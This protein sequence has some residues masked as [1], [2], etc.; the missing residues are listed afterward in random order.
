MNDDATLLRD[1]CWKLYAEHCTHMR[2]HETQRST[3]AASILAIAT[4][5]V[6][7]ITFDKKIVPSDVPLALLLILLGCFGAIFSA[8]HY[9][10]AS[11]HTE[12]ARRFRD[13]IDSTLA[14][15]PLKKLKQAADAAH[16][17]DFPRLEKLRLNK[18]WVGLYLLLAAMGLALTIVAVWFPYSAP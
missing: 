2:H 1:S 13:A 8:K 11:L 16:A 10:R 14:G 6:G 12:R 18:F 9:E 3:V 17:A 15:N 7:L 4:A 5:I